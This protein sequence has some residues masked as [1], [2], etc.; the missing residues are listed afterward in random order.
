MSR[1][2]FQEAGHIL[3]T[4]EH[5]GGAAAEVDTATLR[6]IDK[7]RLPSRLEAGRYG[8]LVGS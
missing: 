4:L 6:R 8:E 5:P 1:S 7:P 3:L 2:H